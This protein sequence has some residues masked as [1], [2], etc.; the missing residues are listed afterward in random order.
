M[1][2]PEKKITLK[3]GRT[4]LFTG[5][6][7]DM[8]EEMI[9]YLKVT[10]QETPYLLR[11]PSEC[12][13]TTEGEAQYLQGLLEAPNTVMIVC[14][15]D[16]KMAGNC[17]IARK[18]WLKNRHRATIGIA[19]L[20]EF[21]GLGIGTAMFEEMIEIAEGWGLSQVELEVVEG[22]HRAK[23]LY[24]RFGFRETGRNPRALKYD[25]GTYADEYRMVKLFTD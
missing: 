17:Q 5:P 8:A 24:E 14:F 16:G 25:D 23:Q 4:A 1:Y 11:S 6:S 2:Y 13:V 3:D 12:T 7:T 19:L 22:N 10:A 20:Q 18:S 15:V 9:D 21:W